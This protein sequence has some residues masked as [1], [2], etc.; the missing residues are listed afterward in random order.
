MSGVLSNIYN[1]T[2]YALRLHS[3]ALARLQ[4]QA[5][6]GNRINR[7]SDGPSESYQILGLSSVKRS[8]SNYMD[9]LSD[10][11]G[12]LTMSGA[13]LTDMLGAISDATK[14]ISSIS[15]TNEGAAISV[16]IEALNSALEQMVSAANSRRVS[17]VYLFGG[18][19]T[20]SAPYTVTRTDGKIT[21]VSYQGGGQERTVEVADGIEV[22]E[23]YVGDNIFRSDNRQ[24]PAFAGTT[25]AA[26]GSGTSNVRGDVQ[27][28]VTH[29]G[30]NYKLSIDGGAEVTVQGVITNLAVTDTDGNVLY[31]DATNITSTGEEWVRVPGTYDIF[32]ALISIRDKL[33]SGADINELRSNALESFGEIKSLLTGTSVT[34]GSK[35][36]FLTNLN[37]NLEN[38]E[39]NA[40]DESARL[41]Q[42]DIAEISIDLA[43]RE[44]LYQMTL[45]VSGKLM[46]MSLLDFIS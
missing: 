35:I 36:G 25:G 29:D 33:E 10:V 24:A 40:D 38:M 5:Y 6:T 14:N 41:Q 45:A 12:K 42:A 2:S 21:S 31:V 7:P 1:N 9:N 34:V 22:T 20:S 15:G 19:N 26:A 30:S 43:R 39:F 46:S 44:V 23:Y 8:L 11:V 28:T 16:A 3:E 27:L 4:E 37:E 13:A 32:N 18:N 17:G